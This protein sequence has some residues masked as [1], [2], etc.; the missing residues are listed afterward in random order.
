MTLVDERT[1]TAPLLLT[2]CAACVTTGGLFCEKSGIKRGAPK[3]PF[4]L[5]KLK[6]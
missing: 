6:G 4:N 2:T 1:G 5:N 3:K